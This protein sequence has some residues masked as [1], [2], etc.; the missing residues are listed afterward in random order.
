MEY[1]NL[2]QEELYLINKDLII[3]LLDKADETIKLINKHE[4][5]SLEDVKHSI[6][7]TI[8]NT[9]EIENEFDARESYYELFFEYEIGLIDREK[10]IGKI[11]K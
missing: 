6:Y 4:E 2:Q 1:I 9:I 3:D 11:I 8:L 7:D 5:E 10:L